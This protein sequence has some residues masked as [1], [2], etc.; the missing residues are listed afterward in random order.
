VKH[1]N[2]YASL[3]NSLPRVVFPALT[4]CDDQEGDG[5]GEEKEDEYKCVSKPVR[6]FT[7]AHDTFQTVKLFFYAYNIGEHDEKILNMERLLK[8]KFSMKQISFQAFWWRNKY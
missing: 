3:G 8:H 2:A 6:N 1:L 4:S 7:E 5:D